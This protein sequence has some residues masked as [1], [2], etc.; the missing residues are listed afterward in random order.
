MSYRIV[1]DLHVQYIAL[2]INSYAINQSTNQFLEWPMCDATARTTMGVTL[3]KCLII[4]S[5]NDCWNILHFNCCLKADNE[6]KVNIMLSRSD[7]VS[8]AHHF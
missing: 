8:S 2:Y 1:V 6:E 4:M 7:S 5:G 3:K